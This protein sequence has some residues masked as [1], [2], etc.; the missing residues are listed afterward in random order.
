MSQKERD[1]LTILAGVK[2]QELN[3]VQAAELME[4]SYRQTKRLW[5]RYR[6]E[7]DAGLVHR[8]RGK[9]SGRRKPPALRA[10]VLARAVQQRYADFGPTL[11]AEYL[12]AEGLEVH[13]E[14]LRRWLLA[15]SVRKRCRR[16]SPHR[17]WRQR[18]PCFGAMVQMDG[19]HHDWFEGQRPPCVLMVMVDD[20]TNR[21]RALFSEEETT[22]A[23]YDVLEGWARQHGLPRSL[24]VDRDSIY[25]CEGEPSVAEQLAGKEPQT[26][27]GRAM[28]QLGVKLILAR[29][30]QAKGRVERMNGV[31]QDRLV[32]AMRLAGVRDLESGNRFL[33]EKFLP[34]FNRRFA[35]RPASA[36]DVHRAA[37][38]DL[39]EV[40]S[41]EEERVVQ[42]D[43]TVACGGRWYQLDRRHE[44]LS[45]A[46]RRVI[47]RRLRDGRE[48]L[49]YRGEKLKWRALPGRPER[50][51]QK[52]SSEKAERP[53][54][55]KSK[56]A[57]AHPWRRFGIAAS[58]AYWKR[59]NGARGGGPLPPGPPPRAPE[60]NNGNNSDNNH[61][62]GRAKRATTTT[63]KKGTFLTSRNR[64]HS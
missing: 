31:L 22:H 43:W 41:W 14:T 12:A 13:H 19:S 29:S 17:Q 34:G 23:C 33:E 60:N 56:P 59:D 53:K 46:G 42:R 51:A 37:P 36:L 2:R 26:Q 57:A 47:V 49:V 50:A 1:R 18:K 35:R 39:E 58:R 45:L 8:L 32:K 28:E 20:A 3:L 48:Q 4:L 38:R 40:L 25:R 15:S 54:A 27:F 10:A 64:G 63:A 11:L 52:L 44:A 61:N 16:R 55:V 62:N 24:Y 7:G 6:T 21:V 5:R 30:P 9:P